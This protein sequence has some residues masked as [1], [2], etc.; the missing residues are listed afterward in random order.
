MPWKTE[1][2]AKQR[3]NFIE[4]LVKRRGGVA[5]VCRQFK[6]SRTCGYKWWR[7]FKRSGGGGLNDRRRRPKAAE[8]LKRCWMAKV[9]RLRRRYG[10]GARKV[11]ALLPGWC[12]GQ[13]RPS[14]RTITRWL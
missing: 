6:I 4:A 3:R 8:R 7:R 14:V 9:V 5:V 1:G 12:A 11:H 13:R 10:W 2:V